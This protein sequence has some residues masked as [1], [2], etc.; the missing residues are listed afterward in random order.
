[1]VECDRCDGYGNSDF[2]EAGLPYACYACC[3][4]G[5]MPVEAQWD[6][7]Q[8]LAELRNPQQHFMARYPA[9]PP[10]LMAPRPASWWA[11]D[12]DLPF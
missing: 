7:P 5:W 9:P 3:C 2:D 1:M 11:N 8:I 12:D 6:E 10:H 4:T